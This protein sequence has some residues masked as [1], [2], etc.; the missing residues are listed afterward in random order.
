MATIT[1][2]ITIVSPVKNQRCQ[3]PAFARKLKAAPVLCMRTMLKKGVTSRTSPGVKAALT[4][5]LVARSRT[6]TAALTASQRVQAG[7]AS[8]MPPLL[9]RALEI[10][11]AARADRRVPLVASDIGAVVPASFALGVG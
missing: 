8:G 10:R 6:T 9:A 1:V 11:H 4:H 7:R 3:P 2:A 5:A